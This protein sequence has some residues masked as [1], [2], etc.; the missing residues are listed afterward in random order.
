VQ[1]TLFVSV[2]ETGQLE[3][4][5]SPSSGWWIPMA[6]GWRRWSRR[7][8]RPRGHLTVRGF[9]F[10]SGVTGDPDVSWVKADGSASGTII[11]NGWD[12]DWHW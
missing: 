1:I 11:T 4:G 6:V 3:I 10:T 7:P 5:T 12:P 2:G 9:A 8:P